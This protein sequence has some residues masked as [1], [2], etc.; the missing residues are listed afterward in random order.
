M[1]EKVFNKSTA[2]IGSESTQNESIYEENKLE[3]WLIA[4]IF[5]SIA[6]IAVIGNG[7]ILY[8]THI[9]KNNGPLKILDIVIKNLAVA[10]MLF[11]L[12]G[13]PTRLIV[14]KFEGIY[15]LILNFAGWFKILQPESISIM[16]AL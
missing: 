5:L 11:G 14:T 4:I 12:I 10:D 6:V 9:H 1:I 15:Q 7:M 2:S 13:I 16:C 3:L 8:I